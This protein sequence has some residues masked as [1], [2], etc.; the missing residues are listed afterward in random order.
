MDDH[1]GNNSGTNILFSEKNVT[2]L[3]WFR[4][5]THCTTLHARSFYFEILCHRLLNR[6]LSNFLFSYL[7]H[8]IFYSAFFFPFPPYISFHYSNSKKIFAQN[9]ANGQQC[10]KL[11][12]LYYILLSLY[13]IMPLFYEVDNFLLQ[14]SYQNYIRKG[15]STPEFL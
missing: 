6:S 7:I 10:S 3:E 9:L 5:Q 12:S 2:A 1:L 14:H 11:Y 4:S 13:W 15:R 8:N